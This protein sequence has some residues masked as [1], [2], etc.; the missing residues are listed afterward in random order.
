MKK[1]SF[2]FNNII[3]YLILIL[4][5]V[6]TKRVLLLGENIL[7]LVV[8]A[9]EVVLICKR[10]LDNKG[11]KIRIES[12]P[13][14]KYIC[15]LIMVYVLWKILSFSLGISSNA[16]IIDMEFYT[17]IFAVTLLYL[18]M[19]FQVNVNPQ[20]QKIAV[21]GGSVGSF[22]IFLS[23]LKDREFQHLTDALVITEDGIVSYLFLATLLSI[24]N[25]ILNKTENK[26]NN[27]WLAV[28]GFN[29]FVL[30]LKQSHIS[31][32]MIV[33]CL[34]SVAAFFR[35][36]ASL[37]KKVG[38]LLF[39]F[40]FLW[41]NMSLVLNYMKWFQVE[42][43]YSL[44]TSVYMELC[45]ALGGLLF[46]HFWD[47]IPEGTKLH[48][49]SMVKMQHYFRM[50]LG[51]LTFVFLIFVMGGSS[52]NS[53]ADDGLKGF[54]KALALPLHSELI[55]GSSTIFVWLAKLGVVGVLLF[56]IWFYQMGMRMYKRCGV[57]QERENCFLIYYLVFLFS[58]F[59]WEVPG[60]VLFALVF[61]VSMGNVKPKLIEI[62]TEEEN[63]EIEENVKIEENQG[64]EKDEEMEDGSSLTCVGI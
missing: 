28:T 43:V 50:V 11:K 14:D 13:I 45:L 16:V 53:L 7:P 12:Y 17:L 24:I 56:L 29:M 39:L 48:K 38:I 60:N 49:I 22:L 18:L 1:I 62:E 58:I 44:E 51:V 37:I 42:A 27:L 64:G 20:W 5:L 36:R 31:N 9:L 2:N 59:M 57:D 21:L 33:F 46:F 8:I 55:K 3:Y 40:L 54:V 10:I 41:S 30:L 25:W 63:K 26:W 19:D 47:R 15:F 6:L 61:L 32:W 4:P 23:F 35:P 52:W 34:L